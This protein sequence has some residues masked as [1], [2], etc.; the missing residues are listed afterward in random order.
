MAGDDRGFAMTP[1]GLPAL[2]DAGLATIL[3]LAG[4]LLSAETMALAGAPRLARWG[5]WSVPVFLIAARAGSLLAD[6]AAVL[7]EPWRIAALGQGGLSPGSGLVGVALFTALHLRAEPRLFTRAALAGAG[8]LAMALVV[9]MGLALRGPAPLALPDQPF[10]LVGG[11]QIV[12]AD[13]KGRPVVVNLWATWC[14]PCR[15]E[16]P[17][18]AEVAAGRP[19]VV[20]LFVNQREPEDR[21]RAY[22][23]LAGLTLASVLLDPKGDFARVHVAVGLPVTLFIGRDGVLKAAHLGEIDRATLTERLAGID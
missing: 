22:L 11:G 14:P 15:R 6:P 9:M 17:L 1:A 2:T 10:D 20:F 12:P 18:L 4:L 5:R 13:L 3:S 7:A 23:E 16:M 8:A 21:V 19:D